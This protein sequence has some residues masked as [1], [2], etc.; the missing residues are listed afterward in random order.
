[1]AIG[2][3]HKECIRVLHGFTR[4]VNYYSYSYYYYLFI[5]IKFSL[6]GSSLHNYLLTPWSRV[7]LEK[8]PSEL[9]S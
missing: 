1:M 7:L 5:A 6:G 2:Q 4:K 8:L 3:R 9:C